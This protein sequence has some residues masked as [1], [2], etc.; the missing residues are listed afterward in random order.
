MALTVSMS[1][2]VV[3]KVMDDGWYSIALLRPADG[4]QCHFS[5]GPDRPSAV[6]GLRYYGFTVEDQA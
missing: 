5:R 2:T 6:Q 4:F 3:E 1:Y